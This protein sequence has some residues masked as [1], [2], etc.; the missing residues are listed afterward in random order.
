MSLTK[1]V[2]KMPVLPLSSPVCDNL[3]WR[4]GLLARWVTSALW[5]H[6]GKWM[7]DFDKVSWEDACV[8]IEFSSNQ[9]CIGKWV[10]SAMWVHIRKWMNDFDKN[11]FVLY[12]GVGVWHPL[13]ENVLRCGW[14]SFLEVTL[15][16]WVHIGEWMYDFDKVGGKQHCGC[17]WVILYRG[18]GEKLPRLESGCVIS[19]KVNDFNIVSPYRRV[20]V[21]FWQN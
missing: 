5:V 4:V 12:Q 14:M 3:Y 15:M 1:W 8:A 17:H 6:I 13:L 18:V 20:D 2:G 10:I 11:Y 16:L 19:V 7:N 9:G 21:W